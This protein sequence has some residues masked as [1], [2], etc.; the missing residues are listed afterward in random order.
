MNR[1]QNAVISDPLVTQQKRREM[2]WQLRYERD[3][4]LERIGVRLGVSGAAVCM[5]LRREAAIRSQARP[6]NA[7][8]PRRMKRTRIHPVS[9]S[10]TFNA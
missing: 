3:W 2:A 9:L 7:K 5:L 10:Y 1:D 4:S 8:L 6:E